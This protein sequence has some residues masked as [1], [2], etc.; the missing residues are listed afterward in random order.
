[1][2]ILADDKEFL[3]YIETW[4]KIKNLFKKRFASEPKYNNIQTYIQ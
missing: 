2:N 1:M 3:K 4:G